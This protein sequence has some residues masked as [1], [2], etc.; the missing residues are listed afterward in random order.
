MN[1]GGK[2]GFYDSGLGG[3]GIMRYVVEQ[4]PG[5]NYIYL[6]DTAHKPF[7]PK[8]AAEVRGYVQAGMSF[9]F[10]QGCELVIVAG[11]TAAAQA[12][13]FIQQQ[14]LPIYAPNR[15]ALGIIV[16]SAEAAVM[17]TQN[18]RIGVLATRGTVDAQSFA[19]EIQKIRPQAAVYQ[20][21]APELVSLI[22]SGLHNS[23]E[24]KMMLRHY[25]QPLKG[26]G[27]DTLMLGCTHYEL[28]APQI[29]ELMGEGV[30]IIHQGP[31]AAERLQDYLYR[32]SDLSHKLLQ[33][34]ERQFFFT[35]S[36]QTFAGLSREFYGSPITAKQVKIG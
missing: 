4:L 7:G 13:R 31:V 1:P 26:V 33:G 20:Q 28:I 3:L 2:I 27:I 15:H 5:Y 18:N 17:A 14:F 9:L 22:E 12:L 24:M 16:P 10:D 29:S 36:A 23:P 25:L 19:E 21:A 11:D 6:G 35:S 34:S 8:P 30:K 32:H